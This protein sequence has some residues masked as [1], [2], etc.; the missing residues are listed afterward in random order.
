MIPE[1]HQENGPPSRQA[2]RT[3]LNNVLEVEP[4]PHPNIPVAPSHCRPPVLSVSSYQGPI[5]SFPIAGSSAPP[6]PLASNTQHTI[7][8]TILQDRRHAIPVH[9]TSVPEWSTVTNNCGVSYLVP[10]DS[11][12]S[13]GGPAAYLPPMAGN[14]FNNVPVPEINSR[15]EPQYSSSQI[16]ASIGPVPVDFGMSSGGRAVYLPPMAGNSFNN[17]PVPEINSRVA[18]Q[19]S[20][21][22]IPASFGSVPVYHYPVENQ[23]ANQPTAQQL[24]A[25]HVVP[26]DLPYFSGNP[27]EWP[28]F[29]SSYET[30]TRICG[31]SG[32]ENLMRLQR[33]LKGLD[34]TKMKNTLKMREGKANEPVAAKTR[35]G[36]VLYGQAGV[37]NQ[38]STHRILHV[39]TSHH[40]DDL[41]ELVKQFFL[42]E[43]VGVSASNP[44]ESADDRRA[45]EI[46][47]ATTVRTSSGRF[48]TGL[49]WKY[50]DINLPN[51][52]PMA[53]RR[54][55]CLERRLLKSPELY[56]KLRQQIAE[57]LGKGYA[58]L[59][60]EQELAESDPKRTW[61]LPL[62]VVVNPK[63]PNK[64]RV[65][66][67]A[68][69]VVKGISLNSVLL[70]GPDLLTP[71]LAVLSRYRQKQIAVNADVMEMFHQML[72]R[73][74]DRQVLRF[75]FRNN[76]GDPIQVFVMDVA[77]FGTSC[78][79]CSAQFVKNIN[80]EEYLAEFPRAAKA[81]QENHYV[82]DYLDSVD[83]V[84][85]AI[86]LA[87]DVKVVHERAGFVIRHWMSNSPEVLRTIGEQNTQSVKQFVMD[88][89]S[90]QERILGMVWSTSGG[91]V[92]IHNDFPECKV[93][94]Q[95]IWR[96]SVGWDD[97]IPAELPRWHQ[98]LGV[99]RTLDQVKIPRCYFPGYVEKA[100]ESL[101]LHIF[102]D[103]SES[104][105]ATAA[106]FRV[107]D[108]GEVRCCL[109][110][111]KTKVAP[112]K[113]L[114]IPRLELQAATIGTRLMKAIIADHTVQIKRTILWSDS[115]TV[116]AW[117][118]SD[119]RRYRQFVAFRV[120]EILE[121]TAVTDWRW[122]P[123]KWNVA[124][125]ATKWGNDRNFYES[126]RW[127]NGPEFLY[128]DEDKWP[129]EDITTD[130]PTTEE[131]R[132]IHVHR[133]LVKEPVVDF[134]RFSKWERLVRTAAYV[135][136]FYNN[137]QRKRGGSVLDLGT[138][139]CEELKQAENTV[140]KL[141]QE[142]AFP[143]EITLLRRNQ[144]NP[145][146][147]RKTVE[148]NSRIY[149]LS[150]FLGTEEILRKDSRID[151][152]VTHLLVDWYH[153]KFGHAN[154]ETI[155]NEIRQIYHVPELRVVVQKTAK[156]CTWCSV[157]R[158]VPQI[159]KMGQLP[160]AR[161]T[162]YV[163]AFTFVGLDYFGPLTVRV[164]RASVKRWIALFTCMTTRAVHLE[165]AASLSAE[166]CRNAIR[167]F[168]ARR[169]APQE[170]YSDRGTNFQAVANDLSQQIRA[171]N[172]TLA[173]KIT[174]HRTQWKFNPPYAPHMGGVWE[175]L[176]RSIKSALRCL[177]TDRNPDDETLVTVLVEAESMVN[178][179]PLTYL[180]LESEEHEA[181]TPNHFLLL[182]STGVVQPAVKPVDE[183]G[184]LRSNWKAIQDMLVRFW[185]RWIKEY[186][187]VM[188]P[189]SKWFGEVRAVQVG[190]LVMIA[191]EKERN[192]WTRGRIL[193]VYPGRDGRIRRVDVQTAVG[194]QQRPVS[195][196]A[197]LNFTEDSGIAGRNGSNTGG[198]VRDGAQ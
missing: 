3:S 119:Q 176:V 158:A 31:Y 20:S 83:T 105:Y 43:S 150:P 168:V 36:W 60:T 156:R 162:P 48:Q 180:P 192:S 117:L 160:V 184:A 28:L 171:I 21:S 173:T 64:L 87:L 118:R 30:S 71:L 69:A 22:Q 146:N 164:G 17:V 108:N 70:K 130:D 85:E 9:A 101:E 24:A 76:P 26:K 149:R 65:V 38:G 181:L 110:R 62:G 115:K 155:V 97:N 78:S 29:W 145:P 124:D 163:R 135:R 61:Y 50:D 179:R 102:V 109:V 131:L 63:K 44:M 34:N 104:A 194:I 52:R 166:S 116:L 40:D 19:Y 54:L 66:W 169:G 47:E 129:K 144:H 15:V 74:E 153:R 143:D 72:I 45:R 86:Q 138:I 106:Y 14:S 174:N 91:H 8:H 151:H 88:K 90:N 25:R 57:Y 68:A 12:T 5:F 111:A 127:F 33:C 175:R 32:A 123:S 6:L 136:R 82:D 51:S 198:G 4:T 141:V 142:E 39:C 23:A 59:A 96:K 107:V 189:Q 188:S 185:A 103:A 172:E 126:C 80:A 161:L 170:I 154:G 1:D 122:V 152:Y 140:W 67:D 81:I 186:L 133:Q 191:S 125:E 56:D 137:C 148:K 193:R 177:L 134:K 93:I 120:T 55:N 183:R 100:Y 128:E 79:P 159:P 167:R 75:L 197:V 92:L 41:H 73:P 98:W 114:S 94:L 132:I 182:S 53:E 84:G 113:L 11:G 165:V 2:G 7:N 27:S 195:K 35:L 37:T 178:S 89:G 58:H 13:S 49:L 190:D 121:E 18:P 16:P 139:N 99:L 46:L 147:Q 112:V 95:E 77:I 157:Y 42:I 196:L 10:V 187:P